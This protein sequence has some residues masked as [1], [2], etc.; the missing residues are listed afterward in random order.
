[1]SN[2]V[3][4]QQKKART[5]G[6]F[7]AY[8]AS[9]K[10]KNSPSMYSRVIS[11]LKREA[12]PGLGTM[13]VTIRNGAYVLLYDPEFLA[14]ESLTAD[15]IA[16]VLAHEFLHLLLQHIPR[17]SRAI[18]NAATDEEKFLISSMG[19]IAMDYAVNSL[20]VKLGE[21]R[22]GD[23]KKMGKYSGIYPSDVDLPAFKSMEYYLQELLKDPDK[24]IDR[25]YNVV[26]VDGDCEGGSSLPE[27][28]KINVVADLRSNPPP[29]SEDSDSG[30]SSEGTEGA[31]SEGEGSAPAPLTKTGA[32]EEYVKKTNKKVHEDIEDQ[33]T[34]ASPEDA[35]QL[36]QD[37]ERSGRQTVG[38]VLAQEK[39]RG[40]IPGQLASMVEEFIKEPEIPWYKLL[41]Q[42]VAN[43]RRYS[44]KVSL[45]YPKRRLLVDEVD[46]DSEPCAFPG[47]Q[48]NPAWTIT[49]ALDTSASM[50]D[51]DLDR[52]L[53]ELKGI[54]KTDDNILIYVIEAD[55]RIVR[56][57]ELTA[58]ST[59]KRDPHGRG[60]TDF[61]PVFKRAKDLES[62]IL[63]YATDGYAPMPRGDYRLPEK[64]LLWLITKTGRYPGSSH[65]Y[66]NGVK[67]KYGR[68]LYL[69]S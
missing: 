11:Q 12:A 20:L 25:I 69:K 21:C 52:C 50:S 31:Q 62:D 46:P 13:G 65:Y 8:I 67:E 19:N 44:K 59:I 58:T 55:T 5:L 51:E 68:A 41:K 53:T 2:L 38:K 28:A 16:L 24:Y 66:D 26:L 40:T 17:F 54:Q 36:E 34:S 30:C 61:N 1:M 45:L 60:G 43:T 23:F 6:M 27:G 15:Q 39:A 9:T 3:R 56:E 14:D 22:E 57:Y 33:L 49:F 35:A 48:R 64:H 63:I 7:L 10:Y 4:K 42:F 32:L 29:A 18:R 47:K 37:L